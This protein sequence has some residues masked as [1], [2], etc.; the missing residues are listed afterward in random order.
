MWKKIHKLGVAAK[1]A[2]SADTDE[3]GARK[4]VAAIR[5]LNRRMGIPEHIEGI[6]KA[7][8]PRMAKYASKE[9]NPLY[10]VPV[11]LNAEELERFYYLVADWSDN[12]GNNR[13]S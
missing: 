7:D 2:S 9:A 4:F 13:N 3:A 5:E 1:V 10:P 8:I 12:R 6:R 11:L